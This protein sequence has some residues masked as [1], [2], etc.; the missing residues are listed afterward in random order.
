MR[1]QTVKMKKAVR[2]LTG[3]NAN[4]HVHRCF[5]TVETGT[6]ISEG[7]WFTHATQYY[8]AVKKNETSPYV[9]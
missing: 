4:G 2:M 7:N 1:Y 6:T 9:T 3:R 5:V 8:E